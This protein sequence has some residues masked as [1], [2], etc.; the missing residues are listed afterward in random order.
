MALILLDLGFYSAFWWPHCVTDE[1]NQQAQNVKNPVL[2]RFGRNDRSRT[3]P[4]WKKR[5]LG[6]EGRSTERRKE[7]RTEGRKAFLTGWL[8]L[9]RGELEVCWLSLHGPFKEHAEDAKRHEPHLVVSWKT[10][11]DV[12]R[13]P[14]RRAR[15]LGIT[16]K[17]W[18]LY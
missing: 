17:T 11:E 1:S 8:G 12:G 18:I 14:G 10:L 3:L 6:R 7:G 4:F 2:Y 16:W 5:Q 15:R 9:G 13:C